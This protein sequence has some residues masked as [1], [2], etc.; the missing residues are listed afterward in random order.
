MTI[1]QIK[2]GIGYKFMGTEATSYSQLLVLGFK[3]FNKRIMDA[4]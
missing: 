4:I 2:N 1:F 3:K